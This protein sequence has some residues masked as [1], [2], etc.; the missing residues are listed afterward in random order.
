MPLWKCALGADLILRFKKIG[1]A[2]AFFEE[3]EG[4]SVI[5]LLVVTRL[6]VVFLPLF[7]V[8]LTVVRREGRLWSDSPVVNRPLDIRDKRY[9][10]REGP[11]I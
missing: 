5:T 4:N 10:G 7:A 8:K 1:N 9:V 2:D 11:G 6:D 3:E